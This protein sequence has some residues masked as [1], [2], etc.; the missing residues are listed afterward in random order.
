MAPIISV[1]P[2]PPRRRQPPPHKPA[3]ARAAARPS[4]P[5]RDLAP[6]QGVVLPSSAGGSL[7]PAVLAPCKSSQSGNVTCARSEA[8]TVRS[9][10]ATCAVANHVRR[11]A[12]QLFSP[13]SGALLTAAR[14]AP[15]RC[16]YA[17]P[18]SV[19]CDARNSA[20]AAPQRGQPRSVS[21]SLPSAPA[22]SGESGPQNLALH[23]SATHTDRSRR[24]A[25]RRAPKRALY[26]A[27]GKR[28]A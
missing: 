20:R 13:C 28:S 24:R 18:F 27:A 21:A 10:Q 16:A 4:T 22:S 7:S 1:T 12:V 3:R 19:R 2:Q 8:N 11:A 26:A 9:E 5:A 15:P 25:A 6:A 23:A 14:S 17:A